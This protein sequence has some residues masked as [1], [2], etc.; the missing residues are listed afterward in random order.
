M[1]AGLILLLHRGAPWHNAWARWT[2]AP[3]IAAPLV[4]IGALYAL[5]VHRLQQ[6]R[7]GRSAP[8]WRQACFAG[9]W[10]T[11]AVALISPI[12]A[13]SEQL[14]AAHMVQHELLMAVAA[15]LLVIGDPFVP[16]LVA[17][18]TAA[19]RSVARAAGRAFI[20]R[21]W[22]GVSRPSV[23]FALHAAAIWVW[24]LPVL[25]Q[26]TLTN[27]AVHAAQHVSFLA[28]AAL[29]WWSLLDARRLSARGAAVLYLFLTALHTGALGA[30]LAVSRTSWYPAYGHAPLLWGLTP[31]EDQQ[32]AGLIMWIPGTVPYLIAALLLFRT[33]L[34]S[35]SARVVIDA[36]VAV[37]EPA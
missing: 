8:R 2:L 32:L 37:R 3:E 28:T 15:P 11:L 5:G 1:H 34:A 12:H 13:I 10:A 9:G 36:G 24:H 31:I 27:D 22:R 7:L 35:S 29:F 21:G 26:Q 14:F 17:L 16:F 20:R 6:R 23:A 18:P 33:W 4:I 25:F 19:R 30:L